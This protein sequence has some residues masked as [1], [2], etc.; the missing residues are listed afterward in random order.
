MEEEIAK[1]ATRPAMKW[2]VPLRPLMF[3]ILGALMLG[4]WGMLALNLTGLTRAYPLAGIFWM[5]GIALL[6]AGLVAWARAITAKDDQ[7]LNQAFR[8]AGLWW[9]HGAALRVWGC[10]SYSAIVYR[11]NS[12]AWNP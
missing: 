6:A 8:A 7:R 9:R 5:A 11:G 12:D 4:V 10:R 3:V 2:G 1:A